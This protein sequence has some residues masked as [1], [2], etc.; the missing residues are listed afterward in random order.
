MENENLPRITF[1]GGLGEVAFYA[2][3]SLA[4]VQEL[5]NILNELTEVLVYEQLDTNNFSK[6][7]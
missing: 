3:P 1:A 4:S 7:V 6:T 5:R 2:L